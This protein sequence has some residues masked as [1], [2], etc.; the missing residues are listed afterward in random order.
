[1][2]LLVCV[3]IYSSNNRGI[4]GHCGLSQ[5]ISAWHKGREVMV[6]PRFLFF[7]FMLTVPRLSIQSL[8]FSPLFCSLSPLSF[9]S[10]LFLLLLF[11]S[12]L[13]PFLLLSSLLL[14]FPLLFSY[15]IFSSPL[16]SS[17]PP[18]LVSSMVNGLYLCRAFSSLQ[19]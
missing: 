2:I 14:Y 8:H 4:G 18:S 13:F 7:C 3:L 10:P 12:P 11:P 6:M 5:L 15:L 19:N 9:L 1:M 16:L 17:P